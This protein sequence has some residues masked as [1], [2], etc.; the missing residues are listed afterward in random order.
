MRQKLNM[1]PKLKF[2]TKN[3]DGEFLFNGEQGQTIIMSTMLLYDSCCNNKII[4]MSTNLWVP[5]TKDTL[6]GSNYMVFSSD[7]DNFILE[8][9]RTVENKRKI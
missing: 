8:H 7:V 3:T 2:E 6:L 9:F 5:K 1:C 4:N